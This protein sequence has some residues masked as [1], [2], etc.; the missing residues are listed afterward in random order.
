MNVNETIAPHGGKLIN[1]IIGKHT[2]KYTNSIFLSKRQLSDLEMIATGGLSP[3]DG[4]M[5]KS[6]YK[7][8]VLNMHLT[9]G[10]VWPIPI[11]LAVSKEIAHNLEIG[12]T[13]GLKDESGKII[14]SLNLEEKYTYDKEL[15]AEKVYRTKDSNHPGVNAI[16]QQGEIL[17]AGK[18]TLLEKPSYN[19]YTKYHLEPKD[20]REIFIKNGWKTIVAFQTRNP[21]HRAHEYIQKCALEIVD[22][23]FIHPIVGE[24]KSDD[25]P[26]NVRMKCYE[27]LI[28]KY[29]PSNRVLLSINPAAMRYAG[30]REAIFHAL[31]RK[32]YGATHFI[33][34]RDHAGVGNYYGTYDA[35]WYHS[36]LF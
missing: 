11:T 32:N 25:I 20:T 14:G 2:D 36:S 28:E 16:Y 7:S 9:N 21:I 8:V 19:E 30:P 17:L 4:F 35:A 27:I 31:I 10:L 29:Y 13:I 34:G 5:G 22:G 18:I 26:A 15:E 6:D 24:T 23:L 3:I 33:I 1:R 12:K